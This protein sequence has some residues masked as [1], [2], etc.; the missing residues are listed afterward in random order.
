MHPFPE[1]PRRHPKRAG[2]RETARPIPGLL[3][4]FPGRGGLERLDPVERAGGQLEER[5]SDGD[6][7][8]LDEA[9]FDRR[10]EW[11][12]DDTP[13]MLDHLAHLP[14]APRP[15]LGAADDPETPRH[16]EHVGGGNRPIGILV[17]TVLRRS[18]L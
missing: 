4:E 3:D 12:D 18:G 14:R 8:H 9:D 5:P 17:A 2:G 7:D 15:R 13:R 6:A 16:E 11:H 1:N 10:E